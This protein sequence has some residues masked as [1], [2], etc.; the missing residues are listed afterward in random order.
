MISGNYVFVIEAKTGRERTDRQA[1]I[2]S[3]TYAK[4]IWNHVKACR[5]KIVIPVL[6][7]NTK[8]LRVV[9]PINS[10]DP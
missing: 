8:S 7:Q 3:L 9:L 10:T 5:D 1:K 2:Q 4:N 6:L